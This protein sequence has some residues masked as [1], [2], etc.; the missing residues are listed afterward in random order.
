MPPVAPSGTA[1]YSHSSTTLFVG[2]AGGRRRSPLNRHFAR[3]L[4]TL[5]I[6][7]GFASAAS[8]QESESVQFGFAPTDGERW[9]RSG[10]HVSIR[11]LGGGKPISESQ[12]TSEVSQLYRKSEAGW[13]VEQTAQRV[14]LL[15]NGVEQGS[16]AMQLT[17]GH[18][19][20]L[21]LDE[22]G[23]AQAV[24]GFRGLMR[25]LEDE[26]S[27]AE[28]QAVSAK[29]S[30]EAFQSSEMRGWNKKL[31]LLRGETVKV[32]EVWSVR[33]LH[34][35]GPNSM[36]IEGLLRFDGWAELDGIRAFKVL[37][38]ADNQGA[39]LRRHGAEVDRSFN[40]VD[41][42]HPDNSSNLE[43][44]VSEVLMLVP[45]T[46]QILYYSKEDKITVQSTQ[47]SDM[48]GA[49]G[50]FENRNVERWKPAS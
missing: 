42:N 31:D 33:K 30:Q 15:V 4:G 27:L 40:L 41:G 11:D 45:E 25:K 50:Y 17:V 5:A 37:F 20:T 24:R 38:D 7:I 13:E 16:A 28:F 3:A 21:E 6:I 26:L 35:F 32:G 2:R 39:A 46:G 43:V 49:G 10:E 9:I 48:P 36:P 22:N 14:Q 12:T 1:C 29:M 34:N 8:A 18:P 44:I 19:I 23:E 47:F